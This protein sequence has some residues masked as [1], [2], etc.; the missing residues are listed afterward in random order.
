MLVGSTEW[1]SLS[2]LSTLSDIM[3]DASEVPPTPVSM[4]TFLKHVKFPGSD[5]NLVHALLKVLTDAGVTVSSECVL[6]CFEVCCE[7]CRTLAR[8]IKFKDVKFPKEGNQAL[9]EGVFRKALVDYKEQ[10][11]EFG[12]ESES[13]DHRDKGMS[14]VLAAFARRL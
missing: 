7:I 5:E 9:S 13:E 12:S 1:C 2:E 4:E 14:C 10:L 6:D 3:V 8:Y 11:S